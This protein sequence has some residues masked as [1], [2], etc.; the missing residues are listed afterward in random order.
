M[1]DYVVSEEEIIYE[2]DDPALLAAK[3][4]LRQAAEKRKE[5][6][7]RAKE[8]SDQADALGQERERLRKGESALRERVDGGSLPLAA[9]SWRQKAEGE[10]AD[11]KKKEAPARS[12]NSGA[13]QLIPKAQF[14][15][16]R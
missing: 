10:E 5:A 14:A 9:Y 1:S 13:M 4:S 8:L 6:N 3:R 16:I 12:L 7:D 11:K 15:I 2:D